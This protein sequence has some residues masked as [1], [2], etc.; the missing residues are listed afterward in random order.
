VCTGP[1]PP[2]TTVDARA[3]LIASMMSRWSKNSATLRGPRPE[4]RDTGKREAKSRSRCKDDRH[5]LCD[6]Q[7]RV[8]QKKLFCRQVIDVLAQ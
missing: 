1:D 5:T 6:D 2:R 3:A 4:K 7:V 8:L